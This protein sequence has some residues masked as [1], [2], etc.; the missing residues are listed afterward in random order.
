LL[1]AV[2][3]HPRVCPRSRRL[4]HPFN[5]K[6]GEGDPRPPSFLLGGGKDGALLL[7][8]YYPKKQKMLLS[9]IQ[10]WA[11][12]RL[13]V[14][15]SSEAAEMPVHPASSLHNPYF[16]VRHCTGAPFLHLLSQSSHHRHLVRHMLKTGCASPNR[17]QPSPSGPWPPIDDNSFKGGPM[18]SPVH[19][20]RH[21]AMKQTSRHSGV[22]PKSPST[23]SVC[24]CGCGCWPSHGLH[25]LST[26]T[27]CLSSFPAPM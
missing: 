22:R 18:G 7:E 13:L 16:A 20:F 26:P 17:A 2:L 25:P 21:G 27:L 4:A 6:G 3:L 10:C 5:N 23:N 15:W 11:V 12:P 24:V 9:S 19:P 14:W 1:A 8:V